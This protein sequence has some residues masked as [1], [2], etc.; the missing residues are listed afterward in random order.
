MKRDAKKVSISAL[1]LISPRP[2]VT[3]IINLN[4]CATAGSRQSI[5][6]RNRSSRPRNHGIGS[7]TCTSVPARIDAA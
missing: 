4:V 2:S 1:T 7:S 3:G 6:S 5:T